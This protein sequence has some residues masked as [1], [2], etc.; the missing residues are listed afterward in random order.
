M[1]EENEDKGKGQEG[2]EGDD[3]PKTYDQTHVDTLVA[4]A[5]VNR[6]KYQ[7]VRDELDELKKAMEADQLQRQE[8]NGE[9]E[10]LYTTT[11]DELTTFKSTNEKLLAEVES[12][13]QRDLEELG[14]LL[15]GIPDSV[16]GEVSD[17]NIP[18]AVRLNLARKL[19]AFKPN[20]KPADYK[21]PGDNEDVGIAKKSDF[22]NDTDKAA[23]IHKHGGAKYLALPD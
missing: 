15:P 8:K 23:F 14:Q 7:G 9:F 19:S 3:K 11:R 6:K 22:A 21:E 1:S 20:G 2:Q 13:K 16:R 12:Y 18:L 4:E 5:T 10:K 17:E